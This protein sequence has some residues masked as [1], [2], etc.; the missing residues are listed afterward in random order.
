MKELN[1]FMKEHYPYYK[2]AEWQNSLEKYAVN[3]KK[4]LLHEIN[5]VWITEKELYV[6]TNLHNK[7][8]ERLSFTLLCLAK[9]KN[10]RN[11][12]NNNWVTNP[13]SEI[14]RLARISAGSDKKDLFIRELYKLGMIEY[15]KK[16]DNLSLRLTYIYNDGN[17]VLYISDF[18]ELG[19]EYLKYKGTDIINCID[20]GIS[21]RNNK[22]QTKKYCKDCAAKSKYY[23]PIGTKTIQ[24]I[25]CD[26]EVVVDGIVKNKKRCDEC[27]EIY[28]AERNKIRVQNYRERQK[29]KNM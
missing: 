1:E 27:Q 25:D 3:S 15:A 17:N 12:K 18:R 29:A 16:N 22:Q 9:L 21:I 2:E 7:V 20:C 6:I 28:D 4:Y 13:D 8:L 26:K 14:F 23:Q 11:E 10:L 19:Y 5:G 24:C